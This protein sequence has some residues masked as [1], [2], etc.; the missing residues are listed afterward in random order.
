MHR[1]QVSIECLFIAPS[2]IFSF[3]LSAQV[4]A[5][6]AT[7]S[8]NRPRPAHRGRGRVQH[9]PQEDDALLQIQTE[10]YGKDKHKYESATNGYDTALSN[11]FFVFFLFFQKNPR[12]D[13]Y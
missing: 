2:N 1:T 12:R 4:G 13:Y 10:P 9:L 3:V 5:G 7:G 11:N 8:W 6:G